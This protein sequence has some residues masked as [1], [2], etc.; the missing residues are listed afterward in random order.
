MGS[1]IPDSR[2]PYLPRIVDT[3]LDGALRRAGAVLVEGPK[4]CGKT[5]SAKRRAASVARL[6]ADRALRAAAQADIGVLLAGDVPRLIDEWQL[7]PE[8]WNAVRAEVDDRQA[9][10]QFILT[11][12]ATPA[13]DATRHSGAMRVARLR[14]HPMS[15][16]ESGDS[17]A[18]VSLQALLAGDPPRA[19][20]PG[21]D[22]EGVAVA[23]CRGGWPANLRRTL[24][25][26]M[27]SNRDYLRT[28]AGAEIVTV[29][30]RRRDPIKVESLLY[31][32]ARS[33]AS[34]VSA[35]T[36]AKDAAGDRPLDRKTVS[37]YLDALTRLWVAVPQPAWGGHLRSAAQVRKSPKWHLVDPSLATAA[38][39]ATPSRLVIEPEAFGQLFESLVFRDLSVYTQ[40]LDAR[41]LAYEAGGAELDA[42]LTWDDRWAGFEVKLSSAPPVIDAAA[43]GLV[44]IAAT[45]RTP[46]AALTVVTAT[47]PSYRRPDGV[48]V[49]S[50]QHLGP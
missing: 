6:D 20:T 7:V 42:V 40:P 47:G 45:M 29:D 1:V 39:H 13:D 22:L 34:Y 24:S 23:L 21:T 26:A 48:N 12:S 31:G 4:A 16:T 36:L 15:L 10:G 14:M 2:A 5:S 33:S 17:T 19:T 50:V 44:R 49:V 18:E 25:D 9:D 35:A 11:G 28:I 38:L 41:V 27:A 3:Q 46:P 43:A 32:L 37:D 30:G 8:V